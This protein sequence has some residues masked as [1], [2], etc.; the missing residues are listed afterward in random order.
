MA[1]DANTPIL[2]DSGWTLAKLIKPGEYVFGEDGMPKQVKTV[3]IFD[4]APCQEVHFDDGV[5]IIGDAKTMFP[6]ETVNSRIVK[7]QGWNAK[8]QT[9]TIDEL[10]GAELKV[11]KYG[12]CG[13]IYSVPTTAPIQ[14]PERNLPVPPFIVGVWFT[15]DFRTNNLNVKKTDVQEYNKRFRQYGYTT[16]KI[17]LID[18]KIRLELR[19]NIQ[20]AFLTKYPEKQTTIPDEY[21][22]AS[23]S[24]RLDL[25]RGIFFEK[26]HAYNPS[27]DHFK[28]FLSDFK[29]IKRIQGVVESLGIRTVM[30]LHTKKP[31]YCMKFSTNL[32]IVDNQAKKPRPSRSKRRYIRKIEEVSPKSRVFIDAGGFFVAGEGFVPLC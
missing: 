14:T 22:I 27:K 13:H 7:C 15:K 10:T 23:E 24:Q 1:I 26:K 4:P 28:L 6:V 30:H 21:L 12:R 3:Q 19:P 29:S 5:T 2:T 31:M 17:K 8:P 25:L 16:K 11:R 32:Q 18:S 9:I 20:L